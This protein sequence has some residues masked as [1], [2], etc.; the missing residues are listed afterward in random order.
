[1]NARFQDYVTSTT[2]HLSL[3]R[4]MIQALMIAKCMHEG[5]ESHHLDFG[6]SVP[7]LK[8]IIERGLIEHHDRPVEYKDWDFITQMEFNQTHRWYTLTTAGQLVYQL[9]QE[10]GLI[11]K[12]VVHLAEAA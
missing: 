1:M 9:L 5:K 10:A 4:Q 11:P 12:E 3:S 2:F 8:S 7:A 6:R